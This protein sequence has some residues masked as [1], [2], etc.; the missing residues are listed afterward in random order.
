MSK[1][2]SNEINIPKLKKKSSSLIAKLA[3]NKK[4]LWRSYGYKFESN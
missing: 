2:F 1:N 3:I 4:N